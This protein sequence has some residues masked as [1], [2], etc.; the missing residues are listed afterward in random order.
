MGF[1]QQVLLPDSP[2]ESL[3]R[4]TRDYQSWLFLQLANGLMSTTVETSGFYSKTSS[5]G[6]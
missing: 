2:N 6:H 3:P 1:F 5:C 4:S